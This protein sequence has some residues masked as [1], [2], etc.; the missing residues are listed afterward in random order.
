MATKKTS[1]T[2]APYDHRGNLMHYAET[3]I[4]RYRGVEPQPG[5]PGYVE[6]RAN[7]PFSGTLTLGGVT[8]GYSAK[9]VTWKAPDGRSFPMFIADLVEFIHRYSGDI[10][11]G[12]VHARWMVA[13]RGQNFGIR[14]A[15]DDEV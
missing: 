3:G 8:S 14:L 12:T 10:N 13:K 2:V 11:Q 15:K 1:V 5:Q 4:R 7:E 6:W 9:Y